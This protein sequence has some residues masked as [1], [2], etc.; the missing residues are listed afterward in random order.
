MYEMIA[1]AGLIVGPA[2]GGAVVA[3]LWGRVQGRRRAVEAARKARDAALHRTAELR[4][5]PEWGPIPVVPFGRIERV[6]LAIF[7]DQV[8]DMAMTRPPEL[9][10][11]WFE[12]WLAH[13]QED[14]LLMLAG[15]AA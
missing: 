12:R 3:A 10:A 11:E 5:P 9:E 13:W 6:R 2:L 15:S 7:H 14:G 1:G 8:R 4:R